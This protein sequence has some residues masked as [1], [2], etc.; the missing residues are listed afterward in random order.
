MKPWR[1]H[2]WGTAWRALPAAWLAGWLALPAGA[3]PASEEL[4]RIDARPGVQ[5][6]VYLLRPAGAA[7]TV[8]LL[9]GGGGGLGL[10]PDGTPGSRNF[11]VRTRGLFAAAGLRV[12]VMGRPCDQKDLDYADR[13][14]ERHAADIGAVVDALQR[15]T[16]GPVWLVGTS[17]GTVSAAHAAIALGPERVGGLVLTSSVTS[18]RRAGALP[19][20]PLDRIRVP[21]LLLHHAQ[22]ACPVCVPA[23]M[24]AILARLTQSPVKKL[25]MVQGG[26][27]PVGDPCEALHFHGFAGIEAPVLRT[28]T[29][30]IRAPAP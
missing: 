8:L 18:P 15:E 21:V 9:P 19:G 6:P 4:L 28:I 29:E 27:N 24:P 17:R 10:Q 16:P 13:I 23:E 26:A 3:A 11:L 7:G 22:D 5:V 2:R 25:V 14:T 1:S 20:Q 12:A 30:W